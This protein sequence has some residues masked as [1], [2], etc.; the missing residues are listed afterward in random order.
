[1][2][3][4]ELAEPTGAHEDQCLVQICGVHKKVVLDT[5]HKDQLMISVLV[6]ILD[7]A[8]VSCKVQH[9]IAAHS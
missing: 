9:Q 6:L 7:L 4:G 1:M 8:A 3:P 2:D 5:L